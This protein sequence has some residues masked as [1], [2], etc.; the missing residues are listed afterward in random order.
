MIVSIASSVRFEDIAVEAPN[1]EK[2]LQMFLFEDNA[3][4]FDFAR[5]AEQLQFG[6]IVVTIDM[7]VPP[8]RQFNKRNGYHDQHETVNYPRYTDKNGEPV[9]FKFHQATW[10]QLE[11]LVNHTSL[12]VIAKGVMTVEDAILCERHG[13]KGIIV[14]N[15]GGRQIDGT[16]SSVSLCERFLLFHFA[17]H[18]FVSD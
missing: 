8:L 11:E 12:P 3:I 18:R 7:A 2:W 17:F 13:A 16:I 10:K 5:R 14:S 6:A 4:T 1:A 9:Q 15:H